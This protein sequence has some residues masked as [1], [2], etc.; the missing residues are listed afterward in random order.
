MNLPFVG[1]IE[2]LFSE[3]NEQNLRN[4]DAREEQTH[5]KDRY[6]I[7]NPNHAKKTK[8]ATAFESEGMPQILAKLDI[9]SQLM[10]ITAQ[11]VAH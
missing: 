3:C 2:K 6:S 10:C 7:Y 11:K 5:H 4:N 8:C 1:H 9:F